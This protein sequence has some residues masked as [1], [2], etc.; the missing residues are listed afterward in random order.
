MP[1]HGFRTIASTRLNEMNWHPDAIERR[2][3]HRPKNQVR[4]AYNQAKHLPER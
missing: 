1:S 4:A 3:A 2:L